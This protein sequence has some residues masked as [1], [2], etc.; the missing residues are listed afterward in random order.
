MATDHLARAAGRRTPVTG[1]TLATLD[2]PRAPERVTL[3]V[4]A[5]PHVTPDASGTWKVYHRTE[6]RL[7][8][9]VA[10]VERRDVDCVVLA[11]DLTKDGA[12]SEFRAADVVLEELSTP[13]VGVP[14]N[15]DVPK[16]RWDPYQAP[17]AEEFARRYAAGTYPFVE[18]VGGID[19]VG[20]NSAS[21]PD[22]S[23]ADTHRG[24]VS[25]AQLD[26]LATTLSDLCNPVVVCHHNVLH[27][28]THTGSF[29]SGDFYQ[30]RNA[31]AVRETLTAGGV[32][33]VVSGHIHWPAVGEQAGLTE[34]IAPAVCSFPQAYLLLE[35]GP[36]GTAV[37]LV[38][39]ADR[40]GL[41][42]AYVHAR[43]GNEHG[44]GIAAWAD[45]DM[46]DE[47]LLAE[48]YRTGGSYRVEQ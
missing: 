2:R 35:V 39:L 9:A 28:Q 10:D 3:A 24:A 36:D 29:P 44:R 8:A 1:P 27:P 37:R 21:T 20:I 13:L 30:L 42:E 5:D 23:L 14:G 19:L 17:S 47:L 11:G 45:A 43:E 16:P 34:V 7:R 32:E 40:A 31:G 46:L 6:R 25:D 12:P 15:H 48:E 26:W 22:G 4:V 38:P 33:C 18:R 41:E